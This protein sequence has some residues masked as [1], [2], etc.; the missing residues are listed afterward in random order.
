MIVCDGQRMTAK[1]L[2]DVYARLMGDQ[3]NTPAPKIPQAIFSKNPQH[4]K[5]NNSDEESHQSKC[6]H[7]QRAGDLL[8]AGDRSQRERAADPARPEA[9]GEAPAEAGA[10]ALARGA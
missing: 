9:R 2:R 1:D 6:R 5:G 7:T 4:T 8:H 3:E 10:G